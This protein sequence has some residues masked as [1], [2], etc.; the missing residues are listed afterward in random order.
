MIQLLPP[1]HFDSF[2][3]LLQRSFP[4]DEYRAYED[5]RASLDDPAYHPYVLRDE[6]QAISGLITVW[7]FDHFAYVEHLAVDPAQRCHGL[8]AFL[9][10]QAQALHPKRFCLEVELPESE[11]SRRRIGFYRRNGFA[12]ND[13]YPYLQP[14]L[15]EGRRSIPLILMTTGGTASAGELDGIRDVLYARVY[16]CKPE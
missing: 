2:Y 11:L 4:T 16:R 15:G 7:D 13:S 5:Q 12:L 14:S 3:A 1:E 10:Q 8:G 6:A 9:L